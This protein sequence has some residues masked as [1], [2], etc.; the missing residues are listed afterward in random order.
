MAQGDIVQ[1]IPTGSVH[2]F[3]MESVVPGFIKCNGATIS[4]TTYAALFAVIGIT[5]GSGDGSTTFEVP[6]YRGEFMRAWDDG[7]GVDSGRSIASAQAEDTKPHN[8]TASSNSTGAHSHSVKWQS[9]NDS[10]TSITSGGDWEVK[11][12]TYDDAHVWSNRSSSYTYIANNS[13]HSHTITVDN[14]GT[15]ETRPRNTAIMYCI[16]I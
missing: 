10:G 14:S 7:R 15:T 9:R 12:T 11:G 2:M 13:D 4:R 6:E 8:H 3:P 1:M 16:K 5:Y